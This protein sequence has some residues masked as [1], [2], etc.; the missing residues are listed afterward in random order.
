MLIA[1]LIIYFEKKNLKI[2]FRSWSTVFKKT[3]KE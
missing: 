1:L 3:H 2:C